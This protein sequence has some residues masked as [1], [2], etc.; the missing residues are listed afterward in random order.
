MINIT[1]LSTLGPKISKRR[2]NGSR[3]RSAALFNDFGIAR[4]K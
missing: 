3:T 2:K 4:Q 1:V